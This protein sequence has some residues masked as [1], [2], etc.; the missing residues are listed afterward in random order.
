MRSSARNAVVHQ[1][2]EEAMR[3]MIDDGRWMARFARTI[4]HNRGE[5]EHAGWGSAAHP[6][7]RRVAAASCEHA[8]D[9]RRGRVRGDCLRSIQASEYHGLRKPELV[10]VQ[11]DECA[12]KLQRIDAVVLCLRAP[13]RG[14]RRQARASRASKAARW[15]L[16]TFVLPAPGSPRNAEKIDI[17]ASCTRTSFWR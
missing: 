2:T 1:A 9:A 5:R 4:A 8:E 14:C 6:S 15:R 17:V 3:A 13:I 12:H 11:A 16:R 7:F 10:A